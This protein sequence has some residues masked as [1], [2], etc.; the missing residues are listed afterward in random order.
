MVSE[1]Q[2]A[3]MDYDYLKTLLKHRDPHSG[4][5]NRKMTLDS[6]FSC[7]QLFTP[8]RQRL[9]NSQDVEGWVQLKAKTTTTRPIQVE[10]TADGQ[11]QTK[12][13]MEG[14]VGEYERESFSDD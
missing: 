8:R 4:G 10:T 2:Q 13:L 11:V 12:F 6:L 5:L 14:E 3:Y 1:W 7:L 9:C